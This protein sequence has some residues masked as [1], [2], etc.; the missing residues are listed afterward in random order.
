ML[1]SASL[2]L[3]GDHPMPPLTGFQTLRSEMVGLTLSHLEAF[4]EFQTQQFEGLHYVI[5]VCM[6]GGSLHGVVGSESRGFD[7]LV[8]GVPSKTT[9]GR[10]CYRCQLINQYDNADISR[11]HIL[12]C[13]A[14]MLRAQCHRSNARGIWRQPAYGKSV[15]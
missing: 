7:F 8:H 13:K 4:Q 14:S 12:G 6:L 11:K 1:G 10:G 3:C 9:W 2:Q 15:S 5:E